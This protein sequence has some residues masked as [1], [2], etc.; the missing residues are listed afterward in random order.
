MT[1]R[2][3]PERHIVALGGSGISD[4]PSDRLL[5]DFIFRLTRKRRPKICY[6]PTATGDAKDNIAS[7]LEAFPAT[8]AKASHLSV[9]RGCGV[10]DPAAHLAAQDIVY[11]GGGCTA[12]MLALWRLHGID[13]MLARAWRGGV[14]MAGMSAGMI[15]WFEEALTTSFGPGANPLRGCLG[16]LKGSACAHYSNAAVRRPGY[17]R[18][19]ESGN[20]KPGYAADNCAALHFVGGRLRESVSSIPEAKGYRVRLVAGKA[21]ET[22]LPTRYLG[23]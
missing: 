11:V 3:A 8:R 4:K 14:V 15:C 5:I 13:R 6:L 20:L 7:F 9:F 12:N 10:S 17:H 22:V 21:V 18:L 2:P 16:L 19:I 1:T 23:A